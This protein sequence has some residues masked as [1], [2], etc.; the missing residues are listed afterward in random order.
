VAAIASIVIA[1]VLVG[2]GP[3][4]A[5]E[6]EPMS[7]PT[8]TGAPSA[9]PLPAA[10]RL[11]ISE[12]SPIQVFVTLPV[13]WSRGG[14]VVIKNAAHL[15]LFPVANVYADP[16]HWS[17]ALLDP[18]VGPTVENLAS[19][20]VNQVMRD[21]TATDITLDGYGGKLVRMSVPADINFAD[22]DDRLFG[23]WT[24][25]GSDAPSRYAHGPGELDEVYIV[26]VSGTR[27]VID[28]AHMPFTSAAELAELEGMVASVE[29]HP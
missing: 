8:A 15:G 1:A 7:T 2:C 20:L 6:T 22:C 17:G 24:E 12:I 10:Y 27:V 18:P 29:I 4:L 9:T 13:G 16:C 11:T 25:A 3:N 21:A 23:T 28:A 19:A 26:D 5:G 14:S